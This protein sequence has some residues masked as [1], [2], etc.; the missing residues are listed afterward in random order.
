[1]KP[2]L[3]LTF[4]V[5]IFAIGNPQIDQAFETATK[6]KVE[7]AAE[8]WF[9]ALCGSQANGPVASQCVAVVAEAFPSIREKIKAPDT[10]PEYKRMYERILTFKERTLRRA[11]ELSTPGCF[12]GN[13]KGECHIYLLAHHLLARLY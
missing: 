12:T 7:E 10:K 9:N 6:G 11:I 5:G 8:L 4:F 1:M 2:V 13:P 3:A